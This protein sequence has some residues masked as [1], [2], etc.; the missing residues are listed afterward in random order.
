MGAN[1]LDAQVAN[2]TYKHLIKKG[3]TH[4]KAFEEAYGKP[5]PK[6]EKIEM[7]IM[8]S[9]TIGIVITMFS[10]MIWAFCNKP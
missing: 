7:A 5:N 9:I 4:E 1:A 10:I 3:Y 2:I 6:A 8:L